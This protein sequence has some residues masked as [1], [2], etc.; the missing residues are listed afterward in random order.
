MRKYV[1]V[2]MVS[3][4]SLWTACS[5]D[6]KGTSEPVDEAYLEVG[7]D[8]FKGVQSDGGVYTL[9]V[10]TNQE[11]SLTSDKQ[12]C[13]VQGTGSGSGSAEVQIELKEN[14]EAD[15]RTATLLLTAVQQEDLS[16]EIQ[17]EQPGKAYQADAHYKIPVVFQVLYAN[18]NNENQYV[19]EGHLKEVLDRVNLLY[20]QS[21]V[22]MNL[23]FVM[24]EE[25]PDGKQMEEP[26]VNR[27]AWTSS[28]I[29][30]EKFMSSS[31]E[32]Y[33]N[34][35]WDPNRYINVFLYTFST[36]NILGI[37]QFPFVVAPDALPGV[38]QWQGEVPGVEQ[39]NRP[40]C[41]SINNRYVYD[42]SDP[43]SP[44][45]P[46]GADTNVAGTL[47]HELGHFLG[48]R[49]V[50]SETYT[51][52]CADTDY[53]EDTPSYDR[54][55]YLKLVNFYGTAYKE[56]LD[57]LICREECASGMTFVSDNIMDYSIS[58]A[59]AFTPEQQERVR[60]ILE[61]AV[62]IPGPK[63]PRTAARSRS[64]AKLDLP[65]ELMK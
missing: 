19:R 14:Y 15:S 36:S 56:H 60:Y 27:V 40:Q 23:E 44:E 21:G 52:R 50:F 62:F 30:C 35:V 43:L 33:L 42:F 38:T 17:V 49:H 12:W 37:S 53:C 1:Y 3:C 20:K 39:L 6:D 5:E 51:G 28:T 2:L 24:A 16:V 47:A 22:N 46:D 61:H 31:E 48:L 25:T 32:R 64:T 9:S 8:S 18:R 26:G 59:D 57:E 55:V 58:Y 4:L 13:V 45:H 65:F 54:N 29:D 7:Q 41:V 63:A 34:L 11:W 10:S